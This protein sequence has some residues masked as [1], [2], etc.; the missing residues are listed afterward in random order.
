MILKL[1]PFNAVILFLF[2]PLQSFQLIVKLH[3]ILISLKPIKSLKTPSSE[4]FITLFTAKQQNIKRL[5]LRKTN[6]YLT[7]LLLLNVLRVY[8]QLDVPLE[9]NWTHFIMDKQGLFSWCKTLKSIDKLSGNTVFDQCYRVIYKHASE[10][11]PADTNYLEMHKVSLQFYTETANFSNETVDKIIIKA[12]QLYHKNNTDFDPLIRF[13]DEFV[14]VNYK[15]PFRSS[16]LMW[17]DHSF[18]VM[19]HVGK[20]SFG[21]LKML[22]EIII[23]SPLSELLSGIMSLEEKVPKDKNILGIKFSI[24]NSEKHGEYS[25][26]ISFVVQ[27]LIRT[28]QRKIDS[29]MHRKINDEEVLNIPFN[30][31]FCQALNSLLSIFKVNYSYISNHH[32]QINCGFYL[33]KR[34]F[35]QETLIGNHQILFII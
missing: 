13:Y 9:H 33:L 1:I 21:I 24:Q 19:D 6:I 8:F 32:S 35:S 3:S 20:K 23:D 15:S 28:S 30:A 18:S 2:Q 29:I 17:V 34:S 16:M 31:A 10:S 11:N 14:C 27:R 26:L 12:C 22:N 25:T 4:W 5:P 7:C